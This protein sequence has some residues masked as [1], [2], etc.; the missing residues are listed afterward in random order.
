L[1]VVEGVD[2]FTF[3]QK[4]YEMATSHSINCSF[5]R[6]TQRH[7]NENEDLAV[8]VERVAR[9]ITTLIAYFAY[10]AQNADG[11]NV[12]YADFPVDH[13]WKI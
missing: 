5:A 1:S 11:W 10:N 4:A 6:T 8:V 3:V 9:Q 7:F 13:V 2:S 12:V